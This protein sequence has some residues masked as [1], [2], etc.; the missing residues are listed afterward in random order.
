MADTNTIS[1]IPV[2]QP[3]KATYAQRVAARKAKRLRR[4]TDPRHLASVQRNHDLT[5][6]R[7]DNLEAKVLSGDLMAAHLVARSVQ[8]G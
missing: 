3:V 1:L 5:T 2:R 4:T 7:L 8:H 6:V